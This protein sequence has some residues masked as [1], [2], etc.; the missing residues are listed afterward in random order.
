VNPARKSACAASVPQTEIQELGAANGSS[1]SHSRELAR[2]VRIHVLR[3]TS[4]AGAAHIGSAFSLADILAVL[5]GGILRIS[6]ADSHWRSR[7]RFVLSKGHAAS[8]LYAVL[9][10]RGFFPIQ[11]LDSFYEDGS[12]LCGHISHHGVPGVEASTGSLGHGLSIATGM[13]FAARLESSTH[14]VF[15]LLSDGEC[16]EGST[17]E[18]A[19]FAGHHGLKNL[20]AIIDFN[21]IQSLA[22]VADV[23]ALEP[24]VSKWT[25]F[26]WA[27]RE[28]DGHD[29]G[30]LAQVLAAIPFEN[31]KPSC[32]I[33]HT[34]KGKGV[35]FMENSVLWHY[36]VARG[37]EFDQ[38]LTE[39]EARA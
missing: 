35:S 17:W 1:N 12:D 34:V 13:A 5:Y 27:V 23:L 9:A 29:H 21:K 36:R 24:L 26:G 19:L 25:S 16:D 31:G 20:A 11:R 8:A 6:P 22:P 28:V 4:R 38:A 3:M 10:E 14:R 18:P 32:I 7:D 30:A 15:T 37:Q 39:L 33:A 2:R